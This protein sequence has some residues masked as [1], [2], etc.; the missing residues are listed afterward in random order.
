MVIV[1]INMAL[2]VV[3]VN[4]E[5]SQFSTSSPVNSLP[6]HGTLLRQNMSTL[7]PKKKTSS[8]F[9]EIFIPSELVCTYDKLNIYAEK[10]RVIGTLSER[11]NITHQLKYL[12]P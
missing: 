12:F 3:N 9:S 8:K 4:R 1:F 6:V 7:G 5:F 2:I 10:I 11:R